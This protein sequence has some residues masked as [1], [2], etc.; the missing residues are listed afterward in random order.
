MG[1]LTIGVVSKPFLFEGRQR[2]QQRRKRHRAAEDQRG[3]PGGRAQRPA[4]SRWSPR[5]TT[6]NGRL[7]HRRRYPPPGHP[8]HFRPDRAARPHQSG[9]CRR[10][11]GDA[12]AAGLAHMG[13]GVGKGENR[14]LDAANQAIS[15]PMLETTIDGARA[16]L[17]NITGGERHLHHRHRR[18]RAAHHP[19]RRPGGQHHLWRGHRT[20]T[21]DRRGAHHGDR[22]GL[23]KRALPQAEAPQPVAAEPAPEPPKAQQPAQEERPRETTRDTRDRYY[24]AQPQSGVQ[25]PPIFNRRPASRDGYGYR[26]EQPSY[27]DGGY[28]REPAAGSFP[29]RRSRQ[30]SAPAPQRAR[31]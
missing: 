18:G 4:C 29:L 1:I 12:V 22:H 27:R 16:V 30:L 26:D 21:L 6:M 5:A 2:M 17:I 3:H 14:M 19:G 20:R 25:V 31:V 10:A 28:S 23:R 24:D 11:R 15:S 8:G 7:P 9:L 13:I